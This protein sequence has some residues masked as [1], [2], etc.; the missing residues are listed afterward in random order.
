MCES[1]GGPAGGMLGIYPCAGIAFIADI[2]EGVI[3]TL[4][5]PV[6]PDPK[7]ETD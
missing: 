2:W 5:R 7:E 1:L 4:L 3:L 6:Y